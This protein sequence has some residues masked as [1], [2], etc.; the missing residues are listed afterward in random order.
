MKYIYIYLLMTASLFANDPTVIRGKLK[1]LLILPQ[2]QQATS[3]EQQKKSL[4]K[5]SKVEN[6]KPTEHHKNLQL[7]NFKAFYSNDV[8]NRLMVE[9]EGKIIFL[10]AQKQI[11][12]N[13]ETYI[14]DCCDDCHAQFI[15][16]SSKKKLTF[17]YRP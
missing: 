3:L 6:L 11:T 9:L 1:K 4:Q 10:E 16:L 12:V 8:I 5:L 15:H 17:N 14:L 7:L 13:G 2:H